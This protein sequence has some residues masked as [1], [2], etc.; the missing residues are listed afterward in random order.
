MAGEAAAEWQ[1]VAVEE[2]KG[3]PI[4]LIGTVVAMAPL[5]AFAVE[6]VLSVPL[7]P[8]AGR[9]V[10]ALRARG[11]SMIDEGIRD[12]DH[13]IVQPRDSAQSGQTVVA[14]VDGRLTVKRLIR[15]PDGRIR[16]APANRE[17]LP[18]VVG[19]E[20]VRV[21]GVVV[22]VLRR[23]GFRPAPPRASGPPPPTASDDAT[24]DLALEAMRRS[25]SEAEARTRGRSGTDDA[26]MRELARSLRALHDCYLGTTTPRLRRALLDEASTLMH[27]L[28]SSRAR[29]RST[30]NRHC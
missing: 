24:L 13:L 9:R 25:L 4:P 15:E 23:R 7:G 12:G 27:R 14:E 20:R 11:T 26:H 21:I 19:A 2:G 22:G 30:S 29:A 17:M 8:W 5:E 10:F 28:A 16:L 6:D 18:L 3:L 1:R